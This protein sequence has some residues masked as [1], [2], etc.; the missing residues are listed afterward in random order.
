M[1]SSAMAISSDCGL[2]E[3]CEIMLKWMNARIF[4]DAFST[5]L[6]T[7]FKL[8]VTYHIRGCEQFDE[9]LEVYGQLVINLLREHGFGTGL[10]QVGRLVQNLVH[11]LQEMI[12]TPLLVVAHN[13]GCHHAVDLLYDLHPAQLL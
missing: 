12:T 6:Y 9:G 2:S 7:S 1:C 13:V 5:M 10:L 8:C 11:Y 4:C 3:P